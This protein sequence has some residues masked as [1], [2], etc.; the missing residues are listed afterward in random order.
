MV[1]KEFSNASRRANRMSVRR[2]SFL[3]D[4]I[5]MA[6]CISSTGNNTRISSRL[7]IPWRGINDDTQEINKS[8]HGKGLTQDTYMLVQQLFAKAAHVGY[9]TLEIFWMI[10]VLCPTQE[11]LDLHRNVTVL[12]RFVNL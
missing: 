12:C 6:F 4:T 1:L 9:W 8:P 5:L 2:L 11:F 10:A 7:Y 3:R